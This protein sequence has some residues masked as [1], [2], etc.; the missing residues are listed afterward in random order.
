MGELKIKNGQ[1]G[2]RFGTQNLSQ[3]SARFVTEYRNQSLLFFVTKGN[4]ICRKYLLN[5]RHNK[6]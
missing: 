3:I 2:M 6:Y 5:L 1:L 4:K